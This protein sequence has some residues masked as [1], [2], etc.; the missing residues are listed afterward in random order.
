[1]AVGLK[2]GKLEVRGSEFLR[3]STPKGEIAPTAP[4]IEYSPGSIWTP[5]WHL[6]E[7]KDVNAE[8]CLSCERNAAIGAHPSQFRSSLDAPAGARGDQG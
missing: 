4:E 8:L 5:A 1:M 2:S 3:T 7:W 6:N